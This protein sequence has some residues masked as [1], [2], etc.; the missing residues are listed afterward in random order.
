MAA[1]HPR[2]GAA[3]AEPVV[4]HGQLDDAVAGRLD[5]EGDGGPGSA[6]AACQGLRYSH[7]AYQLPVRARVQRR[8]RL[9]SGGGL[10]P[11]SLV[12]PASIA[13][14][15]TRRTFVTTQTER[16]H[17]VITPTGRDVRKLARL[18]TRRTRLIY[19]GFGSLLWLASALCFSDGDGAPFL[20]ALITGWLGASLLLASL[21]ASVHPVRRMPRIVTEPRTC[22][23]DD[24]GIRQRGSTWADESAW[25][26]FR[27]ASM[28]RHFIVLHR[29]RGLP[30]YVLPRSAL[31]GPPE[32]QLLRMLRQRLLLA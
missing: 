32:D 11:A 9:V 8:L 7:P 30:G 22:E 20:A 1:D 15:Q 3:G 21:L 10:R 24:K 23:I 18:A 16:L 28:T 6:A 25:A 2:D 14:P 29:E 26:A 27:G 17:V 12:L 4:Y 31:A 5:V 13:N 19:L